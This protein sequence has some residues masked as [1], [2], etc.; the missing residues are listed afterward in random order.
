MA[1]AGRCG[2]MHPLLASLAIN[3][4]DSVLLHD[5]YIATTIKMDMCR[6]LRSCMK[7]ANDLTQWDTCRSHTIRVKSDGVVVKVFKNIA[8]DVRSHV[9]S[10]AGVLYVGILLTLLSGS[11]FR[12]SGLVGELCFQMFFVTL[13]SNH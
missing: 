13:C 1:L 11:Y 8:H 5:K 7:Y 10:L 6:S 4:C 2:N 3:E 9:F 12:S